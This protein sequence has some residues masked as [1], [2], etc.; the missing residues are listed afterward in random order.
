MALSY[1]FD[2]DLVT[3][4]RRPSASFLT[5]VPLLSD[6]PYGTWPKGTWDSALRLYAKR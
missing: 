3:A 5:V 2:G 1:P 4:C 6:A